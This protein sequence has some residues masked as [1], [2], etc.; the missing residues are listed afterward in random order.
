MV[1]FQNKKVSDSLKLIL[2]DIISVFL[3]LIYSQGV[4]AQHYLFSR[5]L[6]VGIISLDFTIIIVVFVRQ[7]FSLIQSWIHFD[8]IALYINRLL[9]SFLY[10]IL[11]FQYLPIRIASNSPLF[12][13]IL[14]SQLHI[15]ISLVLLQ[16]FRYVKG[17]TILFFTLFIQIFLLSLIRD[18]SF[19]VSGLI[20]LLGSII[21][22]VNLLGTWRHESSIKEKDAADKIHGL[23][24]QLLKY[25]RT[26]QLEAMTASF[27]HEVNNPLTPMEGNVFFLRE[28][29]EI[30]ASLVDSGKIPDPNIREIISNTVDE[31]SAI[32]R[33][34]E[35]GFSRIQK[36]I[37]RIKHVY[38]VNANEN[39]QRLDAVRVLKDVITL[40]VP[41]HIRSIVSIKAPEKIEIYIQEIDLVSLFSN[42]IKN[43][44]EAVSDMEREKEIIIELD[45]RT[46]HTSHMQFIVKDNG[47]GFTGKMDSEG[48]GL[49]LDICSSICEEN[50]G[51]MET[52]NRETGGAWVKILLPL[53]I[54]KLI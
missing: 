22:L 23:K 33:Q 10:T 6:M 28:Q 34:Y 45:I 27:I 18:Y 20:L 41:Q 8:R 31:L 36:L 25:E 51:F 7:H 12:L 5:F 19:S 46:S 47:P 9:L 30:L 39:P 43:A 2:T 24:T 42:P 4:T 37:N 1:L 15:W 3:L 53:N 52:G 40:T 13:V 26:R 48:M 21:Y 29:H 38:L 16:G 11:L 50:G 32:C 44:I 35:I 49:G 14:G 54:D 17:T